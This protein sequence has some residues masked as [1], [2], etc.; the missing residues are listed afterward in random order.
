MGYLVLRPGYFIMEQLSS[1]FIGEGLLAFLIPINAA[2][3]IYSQKK[4]KEGMMMALGGM[5]FDLLY[6]G[7]YTTVG[8]VLLDLE[9]VPFV[10]GIGFAILF[11]MTYKSI[12]ALLTDH[13]R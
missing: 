11:N 8:L 9:V 3:I 2:I 12:H 6:T 10:L 1:F 7:V 4:P 5:V 13:R